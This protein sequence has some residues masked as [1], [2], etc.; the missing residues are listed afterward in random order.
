[1]HCMLKWL[2][3]INKIKIDILRFVWKDLKFKGKMEYKM[4]YK[5]K[6]M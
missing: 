6:H 1:M 2:N 3:L 4:Y 5:Y